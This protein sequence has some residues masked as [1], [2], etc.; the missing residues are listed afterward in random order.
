M[1]QFPHTM[2]VIGSDADVGKTLVSAVLVSGLQ[3][4]YWKPIQC[5]VSPCTDTEWV[6]EMTG[7]PH[8]HFLQESYRF[9][10]AISPHAQ[11]IGIDIKKLIPKGAH[12]SNRHLIIE[13]SGG[14]MVPLNDKD[15]FVDFIK[16][17]GVPALVVI[18]N[19]K[20]AVNQALLTLEKLKERN[21]PLFGIVLNGPKDAINRKG[22]EQYCNP[23]R[24]FE[25][26]FISHIT[27]N[28][29]KE[30]FHETFAR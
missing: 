16:E 17:I 6:H 2:F 3:G 5:G 7:L 9:G 21:I 26:D 13:G 23:P 19:S 8:T 10:E 4:C 14:V 22:I 12:I 18:K 11:H 25:M 30:A 28:A 29:L 20:G 1:Y 27:E 24:I 15:F